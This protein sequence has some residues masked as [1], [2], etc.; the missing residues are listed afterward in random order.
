MTPQKLEPN[1]IPYSASAPVSGAFFFLIFGGHHFYLIRRFLYK[2][3]VKS[4]W[5]NTN[6]NEVEIQHCFQ[7][8]F[9][10]KYSF[11][12]LVKI[13]SL[14]KILGPFFPTTFRESPKIPFLQNMEYSCPGEFW[15]S[16]IRYRD[17]TT[18]T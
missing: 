15:R 2:F 5:L 3:L 12:F 14:S 11:W 4:F 13:Y 9:I 10:E 1:Y 6:K 8:I 7:Q 16:E 18:D 17:D